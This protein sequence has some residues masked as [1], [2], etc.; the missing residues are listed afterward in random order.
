[1]KINI[2]Q[3]NKTRKLE[4][5]IGFS[6]L[7]FLYKLLFPYNTTFFP[8]VINEI[9]VI[10]TFYFVTL[11]ILE[12]VETKKYSP[13]SLIINAGILNAIVFVVLAVIAPLLSGVFENLTTENFMY[14]IASTFYS[15]VFII[16]LSY[17]FAVFRTLFFLRQKRN[18]KFYYNTMLFFFLL[19]SFSNNIVFLDPGIDYIQNAFLVVT[20]LLITLNSIR[21]PWIA[22]LTKKEKVYLL[23]L[24]IVLTSLFSINIGLSSTTNAANKALL[25]FSPSLNKFLSLLMINGSIFFGIIFF[26]TLFH[27]PTAEAFDRKA[28]EV[29]SLINLSRLLTQVFDFKELADTV[30]DITIQVCNSDC[31][32]LV[33]EENNTFTLS[34]VKNIGYLE[35]DNIFTTLKEQYDLENI[36]SVRTI[37][38][39]SKNKNENETTFQTIA[40]APL[41][42]HNEINGYL[43]AARKRGDQFDDEDQKAIG[44]FADYAALAI[45]NAKLLKESIEKERLEK[46]LDV[47]REIQ[48]KILPA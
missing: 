44:A 42:V 19:T 26:T 18:P 10:A 7:L 6:I 17:I 4:K 16:A 8:L 5:A 9:I 14:S 2:F 30:T 32:W 20:I 12:F 48:Y 33:S 47:A 22:F 21:V 13:L 28:Q 1:M 31:S 24:A 43:I 27:L 41:K 39:N 40:I 34:A 38:I 37:F 46:E 45:E 25:L 15:F 3:F 36:K 11:Y 23:I 35:A 29:T